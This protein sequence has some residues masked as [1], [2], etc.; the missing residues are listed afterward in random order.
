M[1][2]TNF[3]LTFASRSIVSGL[4]IICLVSV[5]SCAQLPVL[6]PAPVLKPV[7]QLKSTE[8]FTAPTAAWP[9]DHWWV[10][11]GDLQLNTLIEEALRNSP[12][13]RQ[14]QA[15]LS[16]ASAAVQGAGA[17]LMPEVTGNASLTHAKQSYNY[18]MPRMVVPQN[19]NDYGQATLNLFWQPDFWGKNHSALAAAT[20]EQYAAE[21]ELAEA[22]LI[23]ST[24]VASAYAELLHLFAVRD[25]DAAALAIRTKTVTLFRDRY[26]F[27]LE[28][29]AGVRQV[30]ARQAAA[31][32]TLRIMDER[33]AL[34]RNA[35][36]ALLGAGPD[37]GLA[38]TRPSVDSS[39]TWGLP[40]KL[41]LNLL[42]RRPDIVAARF[43]TEAAAKRI[44]QQK[45]GFYPSINLLAFVGL[46][47]LGINH[48]TKAGSDI[49]GAG[50]AISLPIFNT[51]RLQGQLRGAR[52]EFDASVANYNATMTNAL[53]EVADV[54]TSRK[55]LNGELAATHAAANAAGEAYS[56][57]SQRYRGGLATYLDVLT[58]E[59]GK[60]SAERSLANIESRALALNIA[61]VRALGG[62][63]QSPDQ[64]VDNVG[65]SN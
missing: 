11:Y 3:Y 60:I 52:A 20:S 56:I 38:M 46:Q 30:E 61:L 48:L 41:A 43:R 12:N 36:A 10:A 23:L 22:R 19:W 31:E 25:S 49:G 57:V 29:L 59:D 18:L 54:V 17:A 28:N 5:S 62:G 53:R 4:L 32:A 58:A 24:S 2:N 9:G 55:A 37:R 33:I 63:F 8:S 45:A 21:A 51:E 47:S 7:E 27:G 50:P 35:I 1:N 16:M 14:A 26:R 64:S 65:T 13:L 44:D 34:Q 39:L 42:G 6:E 15:R 40:S